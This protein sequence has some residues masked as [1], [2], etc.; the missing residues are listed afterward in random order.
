MLADTI[1]CSVRAELKMILSI[2]CVVVGL[3]SGTVH[4]LY[5]TTLITVLHCITL[6]YLRTVQLC[7]PTSRAYITVTAR[8]A[9]HSVA[10]IITTSGP[11]ASG[12]AMG[13]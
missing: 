3:Q 10:S 8:S 2:G 9:A 12:E 5:N 1:K 6:A 13:R 11:N 7:S 4:K